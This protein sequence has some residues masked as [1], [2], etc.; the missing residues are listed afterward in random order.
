MSAVSDFFTQPG[1]WWGV[2]LGAIVAGTV[3]PVITARSVRAS[4]RRKGTQEEKMH[5]L[6]ADQD[7]RLQ[8]QKDAREDKLRREKEEREDKLRREETLYSAAIE[9]TEVASDIL[10]NSVD[11]KGAFNSIRDKFYNRVGITDPNVDI[12]VE[13]ATK[14]SENTK[15]IGVPFNKLRLVAPSHVL[16]AATQLNAAILAVLQTTT[17]PFATPVTFKTAGDRLD[18][19]FSVFRKEV[20]QDEYTQSTSNRA[21]DSFMQTLKRQVDEYMEQAKADMKAAGFRTTPWDIPGA[22]SA[23][24]QGASGEPSFA[25]PA[26]FVAVR[27]LRVGDYISLQIGQR[28]TGLRGLVSIIRSFNRERTRMTVFIQDAGKTVTLNVGPDHQFF[29]VPAPRAAS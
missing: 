15:R 3:G 26:S 13:H 21:V 24:E 28:G 10:M 14:V 23:S 20:G 2:P 8:A 4:D 18:N 29:R 17:E 7:E 16:E 27:S 5:T 11:I 19:F 22:K 6:K 1:L 12:K 25:G 9:F